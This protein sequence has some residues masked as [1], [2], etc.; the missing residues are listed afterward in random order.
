MTD[1]PLRKLA[2]AFSA[3]EATRSG[4]EMVGILAELFRETPAQ[5]I[6]KVCYFIAGGLAA[7]YEHV[8]LG[9]GERLLAQALAR[10]AERPLGQIDVLHDELG[11]FGLVAERVLAGRSRKDSE[12]TVGQLH[13][14]LLKLAQTSG[15]GSQ[16]AKLDQLVEFFRASDAQ[17]ARYLAR[18]VLGV[19]RL[20]AGTMTVLNALAVAFSGEKREKSRLEQAYNLCGDLGLVARRLASGGPE[21]VS[22]IEIQVGHPIRMMAAQRAQRLAEITERM[23][24]GL[25]AEEKYDGERVQCHKDGQQVRIFSRSLDEITAQYPDVAQRV[26]QQLKTER[27][28]VEGEVVA[29]DPD[30]PDHLLEFQRLMSRKRKHQIARYVEEIPTR[31]F[32]FELLY[33]DGEAL[34]NRPYPERR[35]RLEVLVEP[36]AGIGLSRALFSSDLDRIEEFFNRALEHG[37]EGII[38]KSCAPDSVYRAGARA[39]SWIKWKKD[40]SAE[41]ADTFDLAIVGGFAGRGKRSGRW[42]A[43]LCA[44]Y[45]RERDRYETFCKVSTGFSDEELAEFYQQLKAGELEEQPARVDSQLI[46]S[47]WF[48]PTMVIEVQ[49]AE[50]T[51]SPLHSCGREELGEGL[52]LRFPRFN[53]LR[54]DKSPEEATTVA[55]IL[56][57]YHRADHQG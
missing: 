14:R 15:T 42:G 56:A 17:E 38:A 22:R 23:T 46:P 16:E 36:A 55:E 11:D 4:N 9:I 44:A 10:A 53:R 25:S 32:L 18:I 5:I 41:L 13:A 35:R 20:G 49:G 52:A 28:I 29:I 7:E 26:A 57:L 54:D 1:L 40:Y 30:D 47:R 51:R 33:A 27:A 45:N 19:L 6:D 39:W 48:E 2:Q 3:L 43:L 24:E 12:L 8:V 34:L 50:I 21:A 31:L 37:C